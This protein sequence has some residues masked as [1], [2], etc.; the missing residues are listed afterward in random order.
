[1]RVAIVGLGVIGGSLGIAIKQND[2]DVIVVGFDSPEVLRRAKKR[3]AI[4]VPAAS[5]RNAVSGADV[6]FLCTPVETIIKYLPVVSRSI[7]SH[8][9]VTDVGSVKGIIQST[10]KKYFSSK[11]IFVGGHPMA[12][13]E[14]SGL[15]Y[16]D[17]LLFQNAVY[18]LCPPPGKGKKIQPLISLLKSIGARV[19]T[20]DAQEHDRVAAVVSHLPQLI[21]VGLMDNAARKNQR[22]PAIL[23]LAAGGF[24]DMTRIASS[25]FGMWKEILSNNRKEAERAVSEFE[26]LL[27]HIRKGLSQRSLSEV[28][29]KFVRA[30]SFRDAIPKNSKGFL[31]SLHDLFVWVDDKPGMLARLTATLS[32]A[33]VNINDIELLKVRE[34]QG[35]TF[36]LSFDSAEHS[37]LAAR[38]LRKAGF[39]VVAN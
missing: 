29:K 16:A 18:V 14:G 15:E 4:D 27:K 38:F 21:A 9:I 39:R 32:G 20:M 10:A 25:P 7:S 22:D 28:G 34:G 6:V 35:G 17:G 23:R 13:S 1:M 11:G 2:P 8:A 5:I 3:K 12:G 30:K 31:H 24:R 19:L 37:R 33:G 36:R 26:Q